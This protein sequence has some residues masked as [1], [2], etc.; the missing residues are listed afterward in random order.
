MEEAGGGG[1]LAVDE[2]Y[3]CASKDSVFLSFLGPSLPSVFS[4]SA[5]DLPPWLGG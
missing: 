1:G 3:V 4:L 5:E 2:E